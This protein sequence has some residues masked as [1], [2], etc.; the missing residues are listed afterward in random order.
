MNF[1]QLSFYRHTKVRWFACKGISVWQDFLTLLVMKGF[2][3]IFDYCVSA[4]TMTPP[5]L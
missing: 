1:K 3:E 2:L 4:I 5:S